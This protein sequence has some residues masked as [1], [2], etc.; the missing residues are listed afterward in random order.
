MADGVQSRRHH[1]SI[2]PIW[3][4]RQAMGPGGSLSSPANSSLRR[5]RRTFLAKHW[6]RTSRIR[7]L[8]EHIDAYIR[9]IGEARVN[10]PGITRLL[11]EITIRRQKD[12]PA[13]DTTDDPDRHADHRQP[14]IDD[15]NPEGRER[16]ARRPCDVRKR[17]SQNRPQC[18]E[19]DPSPHAGQPG[20]H[21]PDHVHRQDPQRREPQC[22]KNGAELESQKAT[23]AIDEWHFRPEKCRGFATKRATEIQQ[24]KAR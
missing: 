22:R 12:Q 15:L 6:L 1:T 11:R 8:I 24:G 3:T 14:Q 20:E 19:I 17:D 2:A 16:H 18:D 4:S 10:G 9:Q 5:H 23:N 21:H 7:S 13:H